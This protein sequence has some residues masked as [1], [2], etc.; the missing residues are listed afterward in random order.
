MN[1][2]Y[3][4]AADGVHNVVVAAANQKAACEL[5]NVSPGYF[6]RMGGR[7]LTP[8]N[9]A[10][11]VAMSETGRVWKQKY[12]YTGRNPQPWVYELADPPTPPPAG[13]P[14]RRT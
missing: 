12:D 8:D 2:Y 7:R 3:L 9:P 14:R 4:P 13:K 6:R 5:M 1:V 11:V 10:A